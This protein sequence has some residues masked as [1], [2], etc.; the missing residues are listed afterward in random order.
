MLFGRKSQNTT[1]LLYK[2]IK[3]IETRE[4]HS[5]GFTYV[6]KKKIPSALECFIG[7]AFDR[8]V[9]QAKKTKLKPL[10]NPFQ[11]YLTI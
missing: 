1:S 6:S 5:N 10:K 2:S 4:S 3:A 7:E 8:A 9:P 11:G